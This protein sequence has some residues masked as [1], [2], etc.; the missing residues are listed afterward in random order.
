MDRIRNSGVI[1]FVTLVVFFAATSL[2]YAFPKNPP[3]PKGGPGA[4]SGQTKQ[5]KA[6][7][8]QPWERAADAN[9][10]GVVQKAEI[11]RFNEVSPGNPPGPKGGPGAGGVKR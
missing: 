6:V 3:G 1:I 7:V 10:D 2:C 5:E 11:N 4:G 9:K 8:N